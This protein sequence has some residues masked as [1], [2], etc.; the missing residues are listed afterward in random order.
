VSNK[1]IEVKDLQLQKKPDIS[2]TLEVLN[3]GISFKE[4]QL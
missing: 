2:V 4:E 1:G 3:K